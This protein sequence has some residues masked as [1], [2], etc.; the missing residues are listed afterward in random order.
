MLQIRDNARNK[1]LALSVNATCG[2]FQIEAIE[3]NRAKESF[4]FFFQV[5]DHVV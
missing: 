1:R 2:F 3:A 5:D 4:E